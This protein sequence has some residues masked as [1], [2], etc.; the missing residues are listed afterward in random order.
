ML[1]SVTEMLF[2]FMLILWWLP[3]HY[4]IDTLTIIFFIELFLR[5]LAALI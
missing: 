2:E 3:I 4:T 5:R 1:R